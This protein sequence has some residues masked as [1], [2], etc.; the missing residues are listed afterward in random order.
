[1][2][3]QTKSTMNGAKR[4]KRRVW[5]RKEWK[6]DPTKD[7]IPSVTSDLNSLQLSQPSNRPPKVTL[8][9]WFVRHQFHTKHVTEYKKLQPLLRQIDD[10]NH[11]Y[12]GSVLLRPILVCLW[13]LAS[14]QS[15]AV[16]HAFQVFVAQGVDMN[17]ST[18]GGS[19]V[20]FDL[21][22]QINLSNWPS[23][24]KKLMLLHLRYNSNVD[25]SLKNKDG[26]TAYDFA[27]M[28]RLD[29]DDLLPL[30]LPLTSGEANPVM[31]PIKSPG[32]DENNNL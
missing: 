5:K 27:S 13:S 20:L 22:V 32:K 31:K 26:L 19:N 11:Y 10:V 1:M 28:H 8:D 3:G 25:F 9:D 2:A 17:A 16:L 18:A 23:N 21:I 6:R 30:F 24:I 7:V 4:R 15:S 14:F 12:R 29:D